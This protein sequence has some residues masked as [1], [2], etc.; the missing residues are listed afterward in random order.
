MLVSI[1]FSAWFGI[2]NML[3][4]KVTLERIS[5]FNNITFPLKDRCLL[6]SCCNCFSKIDV[7]S[8]QLKVLVLCRSFVKY[9]TS[10]F[11]KSF[12]LVICIFLFFGL[13]YQFLHLLG[14]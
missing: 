6:E 14:E 12:G 10:T 2:E 8:S 13:D 3:L 9:I 11:M 1:C 5:V 4:R 7:H